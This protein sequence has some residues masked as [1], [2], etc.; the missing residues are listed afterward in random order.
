[1]SIRILSLDGWAARDVVDVDVDDVNP[2][3]NVDTTGLT[4]EKQVR[5]CFLKRTDRRP[6]ES[7]I[8]GGKKSWVSGPRESK[9]YPKDEVSVFI[10]RNKKETDSVKNKKNT[11][12]EAKSVKRLNCFPC[13]M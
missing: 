13:G 5:L 7:P 4:A 10:V 8:G 2:S 11:E 6:R 9:G 3:W 12:K 1:M